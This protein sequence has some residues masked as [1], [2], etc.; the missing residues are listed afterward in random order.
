M[1]CAEQKVTDP[2]LQVNPEVTLRFSGITKYFND[3]AL[4]IHPIKTLMHPQSVCSGVSA[5]K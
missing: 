1:I 2:V 5:G 4:D 3:E